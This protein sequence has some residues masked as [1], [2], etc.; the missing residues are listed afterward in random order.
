MDRIKKSLEKG[1]FVFWEEIARDGAQAKTILSAEERIKIARMHASI[2]GENAP[3]HLVFA[4]GF[5]SIAPQEKDIIKQVAENVD[6][7]Y[8][9]VN[10]RSQK[11]EIKDSIEAV[12]DALFPRV[13]FVLPASERL[14]N[15]MLHKTP[16][17]VFDYGLDIAKYALDQANGIPV[18]LQLAAA[19]DGDTSLIADL[20]EAMSELGVA[21]IG[22]GDTRG[23]KYPLEIREFYKKLLEKSSGFIPYAPHLH[24]DLGFAIENTFEGVKQGINFACSSWLGLA[25]RNGL[26]RTELLTFL[27]T[28]EPELLKQR[29]GFDGSNFFITPPNLKM[30]PVISQLVSKY[31]G[32][33]L[34][35][36]DPIVGTGVNSIS[37][38]TPFVDTESFQPFNPKEILG[39]EKYIFV[40][41][42]A[43]RRVIIEVGKRLGY[44]FSEE[45]ILKILTIVKQR[46]YSFN[47]AI[48]PENEIISLFEEFGEK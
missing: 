2:F 38:G 46:A 32:V 27:L 9:A 28:H 16:R 18:D 44:T 19:Y 47:R 11:N 37:T 26:A 36:T 4:A 6:N 41:Q 35:V 20:A 17:E 15:L 13:A 12:K 21:T 8:V 29:L 48:V 39:I 30:L 3:D 7:C 10:C 42:L 22:L 25:E 34:Q 45:N 43:N 1:R 31:T 5:V 33:H 24:N 14:C 40:T 23:Q